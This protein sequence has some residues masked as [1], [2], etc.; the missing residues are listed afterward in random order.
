MCE[1]VKICFSKCVCMCAWCVKAY[2]CYILSLMAFFFNSYMKAR[3][4]LSYYELNLIR[5]S[6]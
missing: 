2:V 1:E 5:L 6:M 3:L 4:L